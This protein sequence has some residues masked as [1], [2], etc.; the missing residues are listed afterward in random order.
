MPREISSLRSA[1]WADRACEPET[2]AR[3]REIMAAQIWSHR[4]SSG[5]ESEIQIAA[6]IGTLPAV[7]NEAGVITY[8]N[9][10]RH[11][12]AVFARAN[13]LRRPAAR[14][15]CV[16]R[17]GSPARDRAPAGLRQP[18]PDPGCARRTDEFAGSVCG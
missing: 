10:K 4:L 16:D 14:D 2:C 6:K 15:R 13:T 18:T 17:A 9:G 12:V 7:R 3:V 11:A 8:P 1:I 5:F